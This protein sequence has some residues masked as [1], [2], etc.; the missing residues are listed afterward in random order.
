MG[1]QGV[2]T[3]FEPMVIMIA[4]RQFG[5]GISMGLFAFG[6]SDFKRAEASMVEASMFM[7]D[8]VRPSLAFGHQKSI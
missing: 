6:A 1:G 7:Q 8:I 2:F 3:C 5:N 4:I